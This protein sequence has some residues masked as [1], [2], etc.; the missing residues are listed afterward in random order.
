MDLVVLTVLNG[1]SLGSVLFLLAC[2]LSLILGVMGILNL[3]QGALYMIGGYI[4][5]TLAIECE[6][7]FFLAALGAAVAVGLIALAMER[8]F[9]R[10]LYGQLN[11]QVLLTVGFIYIFTNA[12]LW[13]WGPNPKAPFTASLLS[14]SF[15]IMGW[16]YPIVRVA[17]ILMGLFLGTGLWWL[18]EKTRL[19]AMLRAGMENQEMAMALGINLDRLF[20]AVFCLGGSMAGLAGVIGAQMLGVYLELSWDVLLYAL[21]VVVIG[22]MGSVQGAFLGAMLIGLIDAFGKTVFPQF[23]AYTAYMAMVLLL[24]IRPR[25]ILGR[26]V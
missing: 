18:Q 26:T 25:G 20:A 22:G 13:I 3:S 1:I 6:L 23:A 5:W 17:I 24:L 9:L 12:S 14:G 7:S 11:E 15:R 16:Q 4:G 2:S 10:Y 19:G 8:G 21:I